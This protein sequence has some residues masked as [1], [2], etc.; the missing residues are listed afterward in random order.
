MRGEPTPQP[1]W[2]IDPY[3][4]EIE[5]GKFVSNNKVEGGYARCRAYILDEHGRL[6]A[7]AVKTEWSERFPD[8]A[9]KAETGAIA[10]A[11][12]F[13]GFGTEMALDLDEGLDQDRIADAP[14]DGGGRPIQITP[15]NVQGLVQGGRSQV[16]TKAQIN[17][18]TR[19]IGQ[20]NMGMAIVP[21]IE[22]A[23]GRD[24]PDMSN[25]PTM[26]L[27]EYIEGLTFAEAGSLIQELNREHRRRA[28]SRRSRRRSAPARHRDPVRPVVHR[29]GLGVGGNGTKP[30]NH[31]SGGSR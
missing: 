1:D 19:L 27:T 9:E 5:R 18:V 29:P 25:D 22:A 30:S 26:V 10:R 15:S 6:I 20:L 14:V 2:T 28:P 8:F 12:A 7:T 4:E 16:I 31:S 24:I 23:V 21:V 17:E 11:L 13:A 3:A